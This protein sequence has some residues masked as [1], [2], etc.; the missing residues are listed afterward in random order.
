MLTCGQGYGLAAGAAIVVNT[1]GC[2]GNRYI[3]ELTTLPVARA[4][5]AVIAAQRQLHFGDSTFRLPCLDREQ[6][7]GPFFQSSKIPGGLRRNGR[8]GLRCRA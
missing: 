1:Y 8:R 2:A 5:S 4:T 7:H 3:F 6:R